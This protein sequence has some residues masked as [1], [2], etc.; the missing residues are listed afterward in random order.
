MFSAPLP[1]PVAEPTSG[2]RCSWCTS[3]V[4]VE[5]IRYSCGGLYEDKFGCVWARGDAQYLEA[6]R[7]Q[8]F[9][10]YVE[11]LEHSLQLLVNRYSATDR[12]TNMGRAHNVA[13]LARH[14]CTALTGECDLAVEI[15]LR[16]LVAW[17]APCP[18]SLLPVRRA[19]NPLP[20]MFDHLV[21]RL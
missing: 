14:A 7:L 13:H 18:S 19:L 6:V 10:E 15:A 5:P 11:G 4:W 8:P 1:F 16:L 2:E 3:R 9:P 12:L 20:L 17:G 21:Y